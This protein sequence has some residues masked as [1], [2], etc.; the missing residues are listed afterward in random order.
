MAIDAI[1]P[2]VAMRSAVDREIGPIVIEFGRHPTGIGR[3]AFY[4][5]GW[6][7]SGNMIG[8]WLR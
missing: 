8:V 6:K 5:V 3:M 4:T 1:I 2:F 7:I